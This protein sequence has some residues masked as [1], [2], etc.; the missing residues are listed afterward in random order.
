VSWKHLDED[1]VRNRPRGSSRPRSRL[2]PAHAD[3]QDGIVVAVDRGRFLCRVGDRD[4]LATRAGE[5]RRTAVVVGDRVALVGDASGD[6]DTLARIVRI[7]ERTTV[8]RRTADDND[9]IERPIVANADQLVVVTA[10]ADPEPQP[11]LLDRCIVAAFDGGLAP[12]LCLTKRDLAPPDALL[13][14]YAA[15]D[16]GSVVVSVRDP[17]DKGY[18][19]LVEA[20]TGRTSV[21]VGVSGVGKSTLVNRLVPDAQRAVG[22]VSSIGKGRHTSSSAVA[23]ALPG[24]GWIV[25]TPGVR[26]FGL[27]HVTPTSVLR[28][29]PDLLPGVDDCPRG[30]AHTTA[31]AEECGL[32]SLVATG[33]A[34][35]ERLASFRRLLDLQPSDA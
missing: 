4:V 19:A 17:G 3:A 23:L 18:A 5:L 13:A 22:I 24:S 9:P 31:D 32:D 27:G 35:S 34:D 29:F 15:L 8:L 2:R 11:R 20:L 30:C 1:S 12:L 10:L 16:V 7:A 6:V 28:G 14:R 26:S 33:R 21:L 25:D